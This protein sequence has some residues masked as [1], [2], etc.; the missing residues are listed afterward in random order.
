V[1]PRVI[2]EIWVGP[3]NIM[4][5]RKTNMIDYLSRI[6]MEHVHVRTSEVPYRL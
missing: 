1:W 6:Q 3:N 5:L 2:A 4:E